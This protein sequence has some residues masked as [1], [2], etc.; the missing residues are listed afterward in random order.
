VNHL[1]SHV[2]GPTGKNGH[3]QRSTCIQLMRRKTFFLSKP[4]YISFIMKNNAKRKESINH[5]IGRENGRKK[6][7]K[8]KVDLLL[9]RRE[10]SKGTAEEVQEVMRFVRLHQIAKVMA[11]YAAHCKS[12]TPCPGDWFV[13][14]IM[15]GY[16]IRCFIPTI[17]DVE[18]LVKLLTKDET[19][20]NIMTAL[21]MLAMYVPKTGVG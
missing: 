7:K 17:A 21:T 2:L 8:N 16:L 3:C 10:M 6:M 9:L 18:N 14:Q 19:H 13:E 1:E 5:I 15:E 20:P 12:A 11:M 4:G